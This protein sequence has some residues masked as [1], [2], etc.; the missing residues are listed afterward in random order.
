MLNPDE[1]LG[2]RVQ[3]G[4]YFGDT[5]FQTDNG[6]VNFMAGERNVING[7]QTS[8]IG[9][10]RE[11][12]INNQAENAAIIGGKANT[13]GASRSTI[14]A[15]NTSTLTHTGVAQSDLFS[16]IIGGQSHNLDG[17]S[18]SVILGG[19][20][21]IADA[22][23]T[24]YVPNL[25]LTGSTGGN[26]IFADG[27][28]QTT[29]AVGTLLLSG[30]TYYA[31]DQTLTNYSENVI[32]G[33]GATN[34]GTNNATAIGKDAK[35][36]GGAVAIGNSAYASGSGGYT[37][38]VAIGNNARS[39][40]GSVAIG[41]TAQ[42]GFFGTAIGDNA[43]I[44]GASTSVAF[45]RNTLG[46]NGN[47]T[48]IGYESQATGSGQSVVVGRVSKANGNHSTILGSNALA[49][50][51][52]SLALGSGAQA[53]GSL[54]MDVRV[55]D[56]SLMTA[57]TASQDVTFTAGVNTN[58]ESSFNG[59]L[60]ITGSVNGNVSSLLIGSNTGSI[61]CSAANFF[62]ITLVSGSDTLI[63]ATNL[64]PGQTINLKVLQPGIGY[65]TI[66]FSGDFAFPS[67]TSYTGSA[68]SNAVDI[69]SMISFDSSKLY[70]NKVENLV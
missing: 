65:G 55:N 47:H 37:N 58:G 17:Y 38:M 44:S 29:A 51:D 16:A 11:N 66:S 31:T 69:V 7:A 21:I 22:H 4:A 56:A 5:N 35:A 36:N 33:N 32:I 68:A 2:F 67:G 24:I 1:Q 46:N 60:H 30:S 48:I 59:D 42:A 40:A 45:G 18:G 41:N 23:D 25:H 54:A 26:L 49:S 12:T 3:G 53:T 39:E 64:Q 63:E 14:Q 13:L 9:G 28:T 20:G 62:D 10:A 6:Y 15:S 43:N 19:N 8:F 61:D 27:T 50:T 52:Y 57:T 70:A 34:T